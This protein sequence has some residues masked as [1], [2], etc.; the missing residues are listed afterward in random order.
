MR[1]SDLSRVA[2]LAALSM[3][4]MNPMLRADD[5]DLRIR[6]VPVPGEIVVPEG[7]RPFLSARAFGTQNY[8]CLPATSGT[9]LAWAPTGPQAT[10]FDAD[11][12]QVLTHYLSPNPDEVGRPSRATWQ[13]SRDSSAV[14]ALATRTS[15]DADFV[16]PGAIPW[17][18]LDVVG[19]EPGP[20]AGDRMAET[21]YI[22]RVETLGGVA[23]AD[24]C[25]T[26]GV[27][28]FVPYAAT[29][30]FYEKVRRHA[31]RD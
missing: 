5:D 17:L 23:P 22:Q 2:C 9:G 30:V 26:V 4:S 10:L 20:D 13:H 11:A 8:I 12:R 27:R 24:G 7:H 1:K 31:R 25:T 14:W 6:L 18:R 28:A 3:I 15:S 19:A 16:A 29:Y 21:K